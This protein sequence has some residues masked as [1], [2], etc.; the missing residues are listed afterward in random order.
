MMRP[1]RRA[2]LIILP[3]VATIALRCYR[4]TRD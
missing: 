1:R 4:R 3:A 2:V